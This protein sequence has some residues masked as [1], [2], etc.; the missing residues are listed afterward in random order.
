MSSKKTKSKVN[1]TNYIGG[2]SKKKK[3]TNKKKRIKKKRK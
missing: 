1:K 2:K 3:I